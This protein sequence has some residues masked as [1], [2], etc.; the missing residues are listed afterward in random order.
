MVDCLNDVFDDSSFDELDNA[1]V[2]SSGIN[3]PA[4]VWRLVDKINIY[5]GLVGV[6]THIDVLSVYY[7]YIAQLDILLVPYR[8]TVYDGEVM[9]LEEELSLQYKDL[10]FSPDDSGDSDALY[11]R[12]SNLKLKFCRGKCEILMRL[13]AR[14]NLFPGR[15]ATIKG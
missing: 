6:K 9:A 12:A 11:L 8:D 14:Q 5:G 4:L 2:D 1:R 10:D 3:F 15:K 7:G 13:L